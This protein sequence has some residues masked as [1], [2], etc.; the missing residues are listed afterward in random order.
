MLLLLDLSAVFDTVERN[1]LPNKFGIK[2]WF[3]SYPIERSQFVIIN[4]PRFDVNN[5]PYGVPTILS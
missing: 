5:V 3:T 2:D 4:G 1:T